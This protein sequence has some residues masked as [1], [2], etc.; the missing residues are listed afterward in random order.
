M[1][2]IYPLTIVSD[3]YSGSYSGALFLAFN[4]DFW[5]LPKEIEGSDPECWNF[6]ATYIDVET[7][8]QPDYFGKVFVG[9][10]SSVNDAFEDLKKKL[11]TYT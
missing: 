8:T 10:G 7:I 9:K 4:T 2:N 1:E 11:N 5:N 6:W 3:R